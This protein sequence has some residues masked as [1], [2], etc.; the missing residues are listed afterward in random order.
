MKVEYLQH[1]SWRITHEFS[2]P[3]DLRLVKGSPLWYGK[4][5]ERN[6]EEESGLPVV[7]IG[8]F[9]CLVLEWDW[10]HLGVDLLCWPL[11]NLLVPQ[12]HSGVYPWFFVFLSTNVIEELE[13]R[14]H[15]FLRKLIITQTCDAFWQ[16]MKSSFHW[17]IAIITQQLKC[18]YATLIHF[19]QK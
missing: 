19:C 9:V 3:L 6:R 11:V 1:N 4:Y 12:C 17:K 5:S 15:Y 14:V 8:F 18:S 7:K 10:S 13:F 16:Y 2:Y